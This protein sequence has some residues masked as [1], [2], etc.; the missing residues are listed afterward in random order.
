MCEE[1][2]RV[3]LYPRLLKRSGLTDFEMAAYLKDLTSAASVI[4]A[5]IPEGLLRDATDKPVLGTALAGKADVLCTNDLDFR[6]APVRA[7]A[8]EHG[9][10]IMS[11][12]ELLAFLDEQTVGK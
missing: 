10:R 8:S 12:L 11:D 2:G 4:P 7:F 5:P 9:I 3:L 6:D 1:L